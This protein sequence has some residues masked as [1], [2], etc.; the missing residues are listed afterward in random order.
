MTN[1]VAI[2]GSPS[3]PSRTYGILEYAAKLLQQQGL[4]VDII[5]V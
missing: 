2:A 3:H 4:N 1:I 5:S